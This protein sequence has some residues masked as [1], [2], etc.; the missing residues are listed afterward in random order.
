[1]ST[2]GVWRLCFCYIDCRTLVAPSWRNWIFLLTFSC[3]LGKLPSC[4]G[5]RH[6]HGTG[7]PTS[8]IRAAVTRGIV[9]QRQNVVGNVPSGSVYL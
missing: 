9:P 1:M 4:P 3:S 7:V 5:A 2:P 8:V 6:V